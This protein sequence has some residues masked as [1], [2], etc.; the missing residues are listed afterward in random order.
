MALE[1]VAVP[2]SEYDAWLATQAGPAADPTT[3][4]TKLGSSLFLSSGCGGCHAI[5][6]TPAAGSIGPDLTHL[7]SRRTLAAGWRPISQENIARFIASNQQI[8]PGNRMPPYGIFSPTE[9]EAI[10][11]YLQSLR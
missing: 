6:G 1:V 5:R 11:A 8:K 3:E 2:A 9:M 7:G 10:T 4:T